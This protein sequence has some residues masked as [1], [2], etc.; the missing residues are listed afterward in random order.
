MAFSAPV[1]SQSSLEE[2]QKKLALQYEEIE[3]VIARPPSSVEYQSSYRLV[4]REW[5]DKLAASFNDAADTVD[6]ILKTNPSDPEP[7]RERLET[8][9]LYGQPISSPG[10]RSI[11]G[12]REVQKKARVLETPEAMYT[13]AAKVNRTR[14]TVRLRMVLAA[15][16][17]VKHI[18][19]IKSLDDGLTEAAVD[20]ARQI[21]FEPAIRNGEPASQFVTFV[22]EFKGQNA[23]PYIP[24]TVF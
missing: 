18:F 7:W 15:D 2:L 20:A 11:Y 21:K 22:Y 23:K 5:Q 10:N 8:L 17:T 13:N 9:R 1:S 12:D 19:P 24:F 3:K 4:L 6:Q 16:G 14:G